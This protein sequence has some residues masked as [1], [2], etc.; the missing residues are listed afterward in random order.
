MSQ[1]RSASAGLSRRTFITGSAGALALTPVLAPAVRAARTLKLGY[2][3]P[4]TGPLAAFAEADEFILGQFREMVKGGL[5]I[6]NGTYAVEVVVKDSQSNPNRAAEVAKE[7]IVDDKIDLMLVASTPETTNPVSTQC[8]I[9]EMPCISTMAPWQPW[10]IGRQ[11]ATRGEPAEWKP[12]KHTY[13]LLLGPGGRDRRLHQHVGAARRPTRRWAAC[14]P[15][16]ATAMPGATRGRLPAGARQ[17]RLQADRSRPLPEPDRRFLRPDHRLQE[18]QR[19]DR[20]RRGAAARLHHVLDAGQPAGLQA[21]G[22]LRRQGAS[23]FRSRSRRSGKTA[24]ICRP[25]CGGRR[26][27]RSSRR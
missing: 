7:L 9:E 1:L 6:G 13:P 21:E 3:S 12:F 25:R 19:R 2:V 26:R 15:T 20:H 8:E 17:G 14:S 5:E 4:Q 11:A 18:R 16:T 24:T 10:F 23:C 27:I 22:R